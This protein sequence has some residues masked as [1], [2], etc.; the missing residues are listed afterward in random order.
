MPA[1]EHGRAAAGI[2]AS[3]LALLA[4]ACGGATGSHVAVLGSTAPQ[5]R[6]IADQ[7]TASIQQNAALAFSRCVRSRGVPS[8]PDPDADG[9][10][11]KVAPAQLGVSSAELQT[12]QSACRQLLPDSG[13]PTPAALQR[14]WSDFLTFARCMRA[15]GVPRWPDPTRYPQ[16]PDRP[17]FDLQAAG[18]DPDSPQTIATIDRCA[19]LLQG[20]NPQHLGEGGA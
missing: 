2:A 16:H 14:S 18:I 10:I 1:A 12:A 7:P 4:A 3:G 11:P 9:A 17:T 19:P 15:H 5:G 13:Q 20:N 8:W 6:S